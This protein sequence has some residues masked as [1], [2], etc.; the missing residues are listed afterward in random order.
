MDELA[1]SR[2]SPKELLRSVKRTRRAERIVVSNLV[3]RP[4]IPKAVRLVQEETASVASSRVLEGSKRV[5]RA[6]KAK[7]RLASAVVCK[8]SCVFGLRAIDERKVDGMS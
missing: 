3:V 4:Q 6:Y 5:S 8:K 7:V 2:G 1:G